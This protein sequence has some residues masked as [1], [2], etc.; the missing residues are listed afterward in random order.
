MKDYCHERSFE[1][2]YSDVDYKDELKASALLAFVQEAACSSA[3]ELGFG[4]EDLKPHGYGFL[5]IATY[6]E[7]LRPMC[8]GDVIT[9]QTWP[10][11]PRHVIYERDYRILNG[12]GEVCA[13]LASRWC[14]IDLEKMELLT[15]DR[16]EA[17][18]RC[19]YNP[20][21]STNAVWKIGKLNG[22]GRLCYSMKIAPSHCDHYLHAN[23]TRYA[24]FF[25]DCFSMEELSARPI[26]TFQISYIKQ[27][28]EGQEVFF[29]RKDEGETCTLEARVEGELMTQFCVKF[30]N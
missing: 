10:L 8:L 12:A 23:N 11:P 26:K 2:K 21:K 6:C 4:Y 1:L 15:P 28:K 14:L 17:H 22:E 20:N 19:P 30:V 27:I 29:Y 25:L 7:C 5:V 16:L 13:N 24:D 9:V 3:D 18:T